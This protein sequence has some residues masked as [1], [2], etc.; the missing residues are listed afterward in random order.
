[1][2]RWLVHMGDNIQY[3]CEA[4]GALSWPDWQDSTTFIAISCLHVLSI[5]EQYR[6]VS[7]TGPLFPVGYLY[8][9]TGFLEIVSPRRRR[10]YDFRLT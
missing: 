8:F 3:Q 6:L 2:K 7:A 1:M 9:C 5:N 4:P 10:L